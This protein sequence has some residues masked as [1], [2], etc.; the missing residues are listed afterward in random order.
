MTDPNKIIRYR[1][2]KRDFAPDDPI[3]T[4]GQFSALHRESGKQAETI[5]DDV[6][7]EGKPHRKDCLMLFE[8]E[9]AARKHWSKMST[10]KL[11]EVE[12]DTA[13]ILHRGDMNLI[14]ETGAL[15]EQGDHVQARARARDYWLK[16]PDE[17]A[18]VEVLIGEGQVKRLI[19]DNAARIEEFRTRAGIPRYTG[20]DEYSPWIDD[21]ETSGRD[22]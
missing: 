1:A 5:L 8:S 22:Q 19:G 11:Y 7:P 20:E 9:D 13:E 12:I 16:E 4:A 10:G 21:S 14:D 18:C 17:K 6:K 3:A 15:I 2:D